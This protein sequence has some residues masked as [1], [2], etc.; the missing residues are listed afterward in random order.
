MLSMLHF[1]IKLEVK[2]S[3]EYNQLVL[4]IFYA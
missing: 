3:Q 1:F 4:K 2:E